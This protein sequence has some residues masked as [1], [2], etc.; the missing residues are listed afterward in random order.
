MLYFT[1]SL[2]TQEPKN[3]FNAKKCNQKMSKKFS[4]EN[5]VYKLSKLKYK[6]KYSNKDSS[7]TI[8]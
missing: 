2:E 3:R 6:L 7:N 8:N 5:T 1:P 4:E